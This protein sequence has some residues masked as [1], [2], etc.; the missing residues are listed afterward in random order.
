M[1]P[2]SGDKSFLNESEISIDQPV[3]K[4]IV[5]AESDPYHRHWGRVIHQNPEP[6]M[7][8]S[9]DFTGAGKEYRYPLG[10]G[11][12]CQMKL[13][14]GRTPCND[15]GYWHCDQTTSCCGLYILFRGCGQRMCD[16]HCQK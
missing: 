4:H 16:K 3:I 5:S 13:G 15:Q 11:M 9:G 7:I 14:D 1:D 12:N 2:Y 10:P 8:C 6:I